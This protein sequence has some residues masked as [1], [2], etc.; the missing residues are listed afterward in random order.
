MKPPPPLEIFIIF[1]VQ[2]NMSCNFMLE[3]LLLNYYLPLKWQMDY[4]L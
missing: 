1:Y 2:I 3:K 4:G